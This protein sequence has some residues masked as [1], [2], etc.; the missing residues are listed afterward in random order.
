MR[1]ALDLTVD[2]PVPVVFDAFVDV[3]SRQKWISGLEDVHCQ[4]GTPGA[5]GCIYVSRMQESGYRFDLRET[6]DSIEPNARLTFTVASSMSESRVVVTFEPKGNQ[7][8]VVWRNDVEGSKWPWT[9]LLALMR[10]RFRLRVE[11][12]LKRFKRMVESN[13][14]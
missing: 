14:P 11:Q 13:A 10:R 7:T 2:R 5:P 6:V 3:S 8:R 4:S 12:D 9:V 1:F